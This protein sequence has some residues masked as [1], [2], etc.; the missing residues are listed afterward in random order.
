[1]QILARAPD[2]ASLQAQGQDG[3]DRALDGV[4]ILGAEAV[5]GGLMDMARAPDRTSF[6]GLGQDGADQKIQGRDPGPGRSPALVA[7]GTLTFQ[8]P[9]MAPVPGVVM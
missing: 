5:L 9:T 4:T 8:A 6:R 3:V 1:V 2:L 7:A